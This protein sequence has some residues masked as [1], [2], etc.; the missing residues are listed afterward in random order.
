MH[1]FAYGSNMLTRRLTAGDRAPSARPIGVGTLRG[2]RLHFHKIGLDGSG[3]CDAAL[4]GRDSDCIYGVLFELDCADK[5]ALDRLECAA[6]GYVSEIVRIEL[7]DGCADVPTYV[8]RRT[9]SSL[10]PFHWY[11]AL[12]VAGALEY[13]L[14]ANYVAGLRA[15]VSIDDPDD[16]RRQRNEAFLVQA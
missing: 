5:V 3:K 4:T 8:A 16:A 10:Q 13:G 15:V 6:G 2:R 14:P 11:K 12:V 7:P 9:R 1:Y